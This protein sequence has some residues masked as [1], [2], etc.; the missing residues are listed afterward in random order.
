MP[1]QLGIG[2]VTYNRRN[3]LAETLDHIGRHTKY[4]FAKV[5]VA[6]DGSTDGTP[7]MLRDRNVT[8]VTGRNMGVAWNKNRAL[9]LLSELVR[10]DI[11]VLLE[12]DSFPAQDNWELE[13]MNAAVRWGHANVATDWMG[14]TFLSG[15][16][17]LND[18]VLS[19]GVSAQCSV[20]SREAL[21]FGG[22]FDPRFRGYGHEHVE[23]SYR[24]ARV[25]YGG[26]EEQLPNGRRQMVFR[27]LRGGI[28]F[29][30]APSTFD[31]AQVDRNLALCQE[32]FFDY[33]YRNPWRDENEMQQFREELRATTP[34]VL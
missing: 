14:E 28:R 16:G 17:T 5:A 34:R 23:H 10:C 2:I 29:A 13:W 7:D 9:F 4:P 12:D 30:T 8:T 24:L 20:Y 18:P 27:L 21:L 1:L 26:T 6:D 25:G 22:Y 19:T 15:A 32:L 31:Q 11:I 33:S 3:L